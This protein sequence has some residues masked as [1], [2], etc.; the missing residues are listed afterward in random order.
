MT[1][2][3]ALNILDYAEYMEMA[4]IG[5][6][7]IGHKRQTRQSVTIGKLFGGPLTGPQV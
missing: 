1:Q 2:T 6:M 5:Q 7:N 3:E 4:N